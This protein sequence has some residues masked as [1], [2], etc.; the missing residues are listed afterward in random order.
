MISSCDAPRD[1][2]F[3]PSSD[4]YVPSKPP[5]KI[6]DFEAVKI[7]ADSVKLN[8]T[9]PK[10]A[11]EYK[12][13]YGQLNWSGV[14]ID[15]AE[16]HPETLPGVMPIGEIQSCWIKL[17][18]EDVFSWS[19]FSLSEDG[20][21]SQGSDTVRIETGKWDNPAEIITSIKTLR[22][23]T[24]GDLLNDWI[25]LDVA[26]EIN[27]P[28]GIDSV[29]LFGESQWFG[30]LS[31]R[32]GGLEWGREFP[33]HDLPGGSVE[34]LIGY[35]MT[36]KTFDLEG[37]TSVSDSIRIVRIIDNLP[38]IYSPNKDTLF[39]LAP[40]LIWQPY[41]A[42]FSFSYSV[43]IIHYSSESGVHTN[44]LSISGIDSDSTSHQVEQ[45][46]TE[47][48]GDDYLLWTVA[49]VDEF[50]NEARSFE[51]KFWIRQQ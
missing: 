25:G 37:F 47:T 13:Y 30:N 50:G 5:S 6:S 16:L 36:I 41:T 9:S 43:R 38:D 40:L 17:P 2:P 15:K 20:L 26:A 28:D 51:R 46:L 35:Q 44:L 1:N 48:I 4:L 7:E 3:D 8:W 42:E 11:Y 22:L 18:S 14:S 10:G 27:E 21:L 39:V 32:N 12:L 29:S 23:A 31:L 49:V 34:A 33:D 19:M 45:N 24:W